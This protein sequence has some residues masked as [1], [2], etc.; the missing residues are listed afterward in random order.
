MRETF[1]GNTLIIKVK[2]VEKT[3]WEQRNSISTADSD[4]SNTSPQQK[5]SRKF[6][7]YSK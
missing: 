5:K 7:L 4:N 6:I 2:G 1:P 3:N